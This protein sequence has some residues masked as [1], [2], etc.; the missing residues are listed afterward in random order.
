[1]AFDHLSIE[2]TII[3]ILCCEGRQNVWGEYSKAE[4]GRRHTFDGG[5]AA[6]RQ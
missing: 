2:M 1:M 4:P 6:L 5:V 3:M